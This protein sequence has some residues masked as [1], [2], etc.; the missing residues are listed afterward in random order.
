MNPLGN[1][2]MLANV[3]TDLL[4]RY[5]CAEILDR[6]RPDAWASAGISA[7]DPYGRIDPD[8]RSV[9]MQPVP[10]PSGHQICRKLMRAVCAANHRYWRF[11]LTGFPPFDAPSVLLYEADVADHFVAHLDAGS[12]NSTRKL[13]FSVQLSDPDGYRGGDLV[14]PIDGATGSRVRGSL[15][16]FSA[17]T[18][19]EVLPVISGQRLALVGWLHGPAFR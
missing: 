6:L 18:M 13:S 4:D 7:D 15:T 19:H 1:A 5:E 8:R 17:L 10:L 11:D 3:D 12:M 2:E 16:V 9:L 14:F